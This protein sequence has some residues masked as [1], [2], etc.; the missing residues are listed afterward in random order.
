MLPLTSVPLI[1]WLSLEKQIS[2][3]EETTKLK[4]VRKRF[5]DY[6]KALTT[7]VQ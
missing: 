7:D 3:Q 4:E 1:T 5:K 6:N 2:A